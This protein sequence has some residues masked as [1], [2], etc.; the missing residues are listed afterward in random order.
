M[1]HKKLIEC[2]DNKLFV[3]E[4]STYFSERKSKIQFSKAIE[5]HLSC[6]LLFSFFYEVVRISYNNCYDDDDY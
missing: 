4:S 3:L 6:M 5:M 2:Q 1:E